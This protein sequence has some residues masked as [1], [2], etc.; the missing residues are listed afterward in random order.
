MAGK[1]QKK[2][3]T[4]GDTF[5]T[6]QWPYLHYLLISPKTGIDP[7]M[8]NVPS[9]PHSHRHSLKLWRFQ[10]NLLQLLPDKQ[11]KGAF[12]KQQTKT[13]IFYLKKKQKTFSSK[14]DE[15]WSIYS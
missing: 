5:Q 7:N 1:L 8:L 10:A 12:Q 4:R 3:N 13:S 11:L 6:V 14:P 15:I 2:Q 9:T